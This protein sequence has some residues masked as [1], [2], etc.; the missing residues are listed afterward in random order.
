MDRAIITADKE[1][2]IIIPHVFQDKSM[3]TAIKSHIIPLARVHSERESE[4][5]L[6]E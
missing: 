1:E 5:A 2:G 4:Y 3:A 6:A